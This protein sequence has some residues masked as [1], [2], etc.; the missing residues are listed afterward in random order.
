MTLAVQ[1]YYERNTARFLRIGRG[2]DVGAIHHKL[3]G[4]GV[5][6]DEAALLFINRWLVS[7]LSGDSQPRRLRLY[8]D[9]GCGVGGTVHYIAAATAA[10]VCGITISPSQARRARHRA[11]RLGLARNSEF[12]IAD[13]QH[14][15]APRKFDTAYAIESFAHS[16]D[17][18]LYFKTVANCLHSGGN[19]L[20][21]DDMLVKRSR[22]NDRHSDRSTWVKRFKQGWMLNSLLD[23]NRIRSIAGEFGMHF[24]TSWDFSRYV[25]KLSRAAATIIRYLT[26][27]NVPGTY[28][29]GIVGGMALQMCV[30][31]GWTE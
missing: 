22:S 8:L 12:I 5:H 1:G 13:F 9:L 11:Q 28:W 26:R 29:Q 3:W 18:R 15:H 4:P 14:L 27:L 21:V 17:P 25:R 31:N 30:T 24:V 6:D 10:I 16:P 2:G 7:Q 23:Q 19:L 20:L